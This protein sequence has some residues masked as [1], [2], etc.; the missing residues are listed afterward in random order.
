MGIV[1]APRQRPHAGS[2]GSV[3]S[4]VVLAEVDRLDIDVD[5]KVRLESRC[6]GRLATRAI[7]DQRDI[8]QALT[9]RE[10]GV[11]QQVT[12]RVWLIRGSVI[13]VVPAGDAHRH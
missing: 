8:G 4:L 10:A 2:A 9:V 1:S 6:H 5:T 3:L 11:Y 12:G 13:G 7:G